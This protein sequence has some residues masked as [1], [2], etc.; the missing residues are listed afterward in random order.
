MFAQGQLRLDNRVA[1]LFDVNDIRSVDN[2]A[3]VVILLCCLSCTQQAIQMGYDV[4][5]DLYL[6]DKLLQTQH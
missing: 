2:R 6:R 1:T 5:I 4:G 3:N